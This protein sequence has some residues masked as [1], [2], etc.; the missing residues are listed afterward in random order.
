MNVEVEGFQ[1][2]IVKYQGITPQ[3]VADIGFTIGG[4]NLSKE[5]IEDLLFKLVKPVSLYYY[6]ISHF[7]YRPNN[8]TFILKI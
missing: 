4:K 7:F 3:I 1:Y 5:R 2:N 6:L 8:S